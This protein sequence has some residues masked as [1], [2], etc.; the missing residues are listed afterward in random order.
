MK[1]KLTIK[2]EAVN[3]SKAGMLEV[4]Q[5]LV[6]NYLFRNNVLNGKVEF[7]NQPAEG[8][9]PEF[10]TLT[11]AA[12]NSIILRAKRE[13]VCESGSPKT[14]IME[15]INSEEVE[16]F[17]PVKDYLDG[18][19]AWDGQNHVARLFSR[20]PGISTEQLSFLAV[21]MRSMVAH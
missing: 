17:D 5:F 18:L 8:Q 14:D 3:A 12:L 16:R 2:G 9:E 19:P 1:E 13:D 7:A 11:Q 21:W 4:E 15:Y 10:R 20:I 6:E